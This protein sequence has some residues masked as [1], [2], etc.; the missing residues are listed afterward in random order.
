MRKVLLGA[1]EVVLVATPDLASLRNAKNMVD[2]I[3]SHRP[4]DQPP[5]LVLNQVGVPGRPEIPVKDFAEA[6]GLTV[7]QKDGAWIA[8]A[9]PEGAVEPGAVYVN[10]KKIERGRLREGQ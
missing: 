3:S 6:M 5:R 4:N 2:L 8:G 1:D 7:S 9:A 10:G